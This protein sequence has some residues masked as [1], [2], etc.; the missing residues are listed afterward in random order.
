[1]NKKWSERLE[2]LTKIV[3]INKLIKIYEIKLISPRRPNGRS[4]KFRKENN[5]KIHGPFRHMPL[6]YYKWSLEILKALKVTESND[7]PS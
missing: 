5:I 3:D 7:K 6:K 2:K 4:R 1:M